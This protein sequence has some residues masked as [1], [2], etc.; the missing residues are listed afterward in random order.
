MIERKVCTAEEPY[1]FK[2][3]PNERWSHP[4]AREMDADYSTY[5]S[6]ATYLC[7]NCN[8]EFREELPD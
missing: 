8:L 4:D 7:P 5:G 3:T 2:S 1:Q 6:Y